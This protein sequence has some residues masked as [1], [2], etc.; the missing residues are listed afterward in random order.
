MQEINP[1][2]KFFASAWSAPAWMKTNDRFLGYLEQQDGEW[3]QTGYLKDEY[4]D[5]FARYYVKA[6][7]AYQAEG[8]DI[9]AITLLNEPGMDVVYPAMNLTIPQQQ[10]LI[11]AVKNEFNAAGLPTKLWIHDF[12]FWDWKDPASTET[13]NYYRI[14]EDAQAAAAADGIAF[15]AYWGDPEVMTDAHTEYSKDVFLTETSVFG[16][17][18][19]GQIISFFRNWARSYNAWVWMIDTNGKTH[20][21]TTSRDNDIDWSNPNLMSQAGAT[22]LQLDPY[23]NAVQYNFDYYMVGQFSKYIKEGARRIGT[24]DI[25][26]GNEWNFISN[27]AFQ[28]PD[29]E[30]VVVVANKGQPRSVKLDW[31]GTEAVM[32]IPAGTV[33][34]FRWSTTPTVASPEM[35]PASGQYPEGTVV[36]GQI[37]CATGGAAIRYT[38]DGTDPR[39]SETAR[40]GTAPIHYTVTVPAKVQAYGTAWLR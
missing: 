24:N 30:I 20:H 12:N 27:V 26:T 36:N 9:S 32:S 33:A 34:T 13:K 10:A 8:I 1:E 23:T 25:Y 22:M 31:N 35:T 3:V 38:T 21:W 7:Q 6:I 17:K 18:G 2:L 19:A 28:N 39:T 15:H 14:M 16:V 11:K 29:G 37:T 5:A 4:I 40:T